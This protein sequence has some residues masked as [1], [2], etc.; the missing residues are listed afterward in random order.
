[1]LE[2][3]AFVYDLESLQLLGTLDT[4]A[5][6]R[7]LAALT[8]CSEPCCLLALPALGGAVRVYDA[9]KSSSVDVLCELEAHKSLVVSGGGPSQCLAAQGG[10]VCAWHTL[11][12]TLRYR[13]QSVMAWDDD[14]ALLSTASRKGTVV[15]VHAVSAHAA[16]M[17]H[18]ETVA[19]SSC[20]GRKHHHQASHRWLVLL[21]Q[22]APSLT[23]IVQV[24]SSEDKA[25]EFRRGSTPATITCLAFSPSSMHSRLLC[26]ASDHG[27][28]HIFGLQTGRWGKE[29][30]QIDWTDCCCE[31]LTDGINV[32]HEFVQAPCIQ[33][34]SV[35]AVDSH[36]QGVG[37]AATAGHGAAPGPGASC[38]MR[39]RARI[40]GWRQQ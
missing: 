32:W 38:H 30:V 11:N 23:P 6:P 31:L 20:L 27:T 28:V 18:G 16:Y 39:R 33:S 37:A 15:R 29:V 34:C 22:S 19:C 24:R 13:L 9:A 26:V 7:G 25:L 36:A 10:Q 8:T 1:M 3:R 17:Q 35:A 5:N 14:G 40:S 4:P 12:G 21:C 2:R